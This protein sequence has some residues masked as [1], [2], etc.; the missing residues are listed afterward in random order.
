MI[1]ERGRGALEAALIGLRGDPELEGV[2]R[3]LQQGLRQLG[4][5][6]RLAMVGQIKKGKSTLV[7]A[8]LGH[9]VVS[10]GLLELTFNVNE[11]VYAP[12][13][14]IRIHFKDGRPS[15]DR[16]P[17]DLAALT[18]RSD[19]N[20]SFL[21]AIRVVEMGYPNELLRDHFVLVDTP[22][23][24][25]VFEADSQNTLDY[26]A[27]AGR[28]PEDVEAES[29]AAMRGADAVIY[30]FARGMTQ[31]AGDLLA[32]FGGQVRGAATPLRAVAALNKLETWWNPDE[33]PDPMATGRRVIDGYRD[34]PAI[35]RLFFALEPVCGLM[36]AG[37]RTLTARDLQCLVDLSTV[38]PELLTLQLS[39][40]NYFAT[41]EFPG[42]PVPAAEREVLIRKLSNYGIHV[43]VGL[44]RDG[45]DPEGELGEE[46]FDRSGVGRL[47]DLCVAHFGNRASI[48]KLDRALNEV[49]AEVRSA[50]RDHRGDPATLDAVATTIE[51]FRSSEPS[52]SELGALSAHY[53]GE[54]TFTEQ[55]AADL[56]RVTG[57]QGHGCGS[58]VGLTDDAPVAD[59]VA[60]AERKVQYWGRRVNDPLIDRR[61]E[62]A[63]RTVH[64]SFE[65][66]AHHAREAKRHLDF[67]V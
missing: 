29:A 37:A 18:E 45:V 62:T 39:D 28:T 63:A 11:L 67:E 38:E 59:I 61:T 15:E 21:K 51:E 60:A 56:E 64:R 57:E 32:D 42:L 19:Q 31:A 52:F 9:E 40:A 6:M 8:F 53:N 23:L 22:G 46:L 35:R 24:D 20:T 1:A 49:M 26:L 33:I 16:S 17:D 3:R 14:R 66:V 25:S 50:R 13:R 47:R 43:A 10:T 34:N 41:K 58:R 4:E 44:L 55:E 48:I 7:N 36:G 30:V 5:P 54:L 27:A 2:R 65:R 12:E